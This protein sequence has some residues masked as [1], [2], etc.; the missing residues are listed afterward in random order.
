[1]AN[2]M[3]SEV[4]YF[5]KEAGFHE[6]LD[7]L[8]ID[9]R[10][11]IRIMMGCAADANDLNVLER[12]LGKMMKFLSFCAL[13]EIPVLLMSGMQCKGVLSYCGLEFC[14]K[15]YCKLISKYVFCKSMHS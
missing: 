1:M 9:Q 4:A 15:I 3:H 14:W 10:N 11:S 8:T 7:Q 12:S 5:A 6:A 13:F 2:T